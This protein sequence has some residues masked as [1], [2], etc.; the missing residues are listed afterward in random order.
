M[1]MSN[2]VIFRDGQINQSELC[3]ETRPLEYFIF[4]DKCVNTT[5][6]VIG[7]FGVFGFFGFDLLN[8]PLA[9]RFLYKIPINYD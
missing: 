9:G 6:V 3:G 2:L 4:I 1:S 7:I 8:Y 5:V